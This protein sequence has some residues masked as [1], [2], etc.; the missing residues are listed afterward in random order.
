MFGLMNMLKIPDAPTMS[1]V[2]EDNIDVQMSKD[3]E[4]NDDKPP[5]SGT[6]VSDNLDHDSDKN[7][8]EDNK[9]KES[10]KMKSKRKNPN[11][12]KMNKV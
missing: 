11:T 10:V 6:V 9:L 5:R 7:T 2:P 4:L 3:S 8:N 1:T 12:Q